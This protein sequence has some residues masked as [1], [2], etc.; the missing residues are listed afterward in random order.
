MTSVMKKV[1]TSL[2][3]HMVS[4][5]YTPET[6]ANANY[7]FVIKLVDWK[8]ERFTIYEVVESS[9]KAVEFTIKARN[10]FESFSNCTL[11]FT[12]T[13]RRMYMILAITI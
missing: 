1:V 2:H 3:D 13:Q 12:K 9:L 8:L 11:M 4:Q 10:N 7:M 6:L 5:N